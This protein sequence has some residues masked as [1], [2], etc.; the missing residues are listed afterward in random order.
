MSVTQLLAVK[1]SDHGNAS[2]F[3][4]NDFQSPPNPRPLLRRIFRRSWPWPRTTS[5]N[6][7]TD[8]SSSSVILAVLLHEIRN[9]LGT[10]AN[11]AHVLASAPAANDIALARTLRSEVHRL[12]KLTD[13]LSLICSGPR[14]TRTRFDLTRTVSDLMLLVAHEPD[15]DQG[16]RLVSRI[17]EEQLSVRGDADQIQQVLW[18]LL[19][20]ASHHG[21]G[22]VTLEITHS[23]RRVHL[24]VSNRYVQDQP[25]ENKSQGTRRMGLGLDIS[26]FILQRHGSQLHVNRADGQYEC[27]FSLRRARNG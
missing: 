24:K 1:R 6:F 3:G 18:N 22:S 26:R 5:R 15:F 4:P 8:P 19:L 14:P 9:P 11:A 17:P 7:T 12:Q 25:R 23:K 13:T 10:L 21:H 27:S 16:R 2:H 20:N